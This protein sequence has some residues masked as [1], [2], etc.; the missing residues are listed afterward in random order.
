MRFLE[1]GIDAAVIALW[2][3]HE[4]QATTSVYLHADMAIKRKALDRTRQPDTC[5]GQY[6][7]V[8]PLLAWLQ[9]L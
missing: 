3:G 2:L 8:D 4:T 5:P 6:Q 9:S 1:A 7:P